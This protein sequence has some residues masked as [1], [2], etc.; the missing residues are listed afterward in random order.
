MKTDH[1][2][3]KNGAKVLLGGGGV[4][5]ASAIFFIL[6]NMQHKADAQIEY[7]RLEG[8]MLANR[9]EVREDYHRLQN[10][11]EASLER[12]EKNTNQMRSLIEELRRR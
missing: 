8:M 9:L 6:V 1:P 11:F 12:L 5:A 7:A 3:I 2:V 4:S 10:R